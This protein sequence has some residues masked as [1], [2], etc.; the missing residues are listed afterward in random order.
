MDKL[1]VLQIRKLLKELDFIET[2]FEYTTEVVGEADSSFMRSINEFLEKNPDIKEV[3]DKKITES[4]NNSIKDKIEKSENSEILDD[5]E[6][7][8]E[9]VVDDVDDSD[10]LNG[11]KKEEVSPKVKRLYREIVKQ[12]HPDKIKDKDL[13]DIYIK[14]TDFYNNNDKVGIYKICTELGIDYVMDEDDESIISY[15]IESIRKKI[16]FLESTFTWKWFNTKDEEE[17]NKILMVFIK[18]KI[19]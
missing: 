9:K 18:L 17:R 11:Q 5:L 19:Q 8:Q 16:D 7:K 13:N 15:K 4:I 1:K 3:Y 14:A 6:D 10:N 2:D 12:T